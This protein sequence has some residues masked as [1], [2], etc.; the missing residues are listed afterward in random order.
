[1]AQQTSA[2]WKSLWRMKNT[3]REYGFDI[4]GTWYGPEDEVT[5]TAD[6]GLYEEFSIGNASTASLTVSLFADDIPRAAVVKRY[7]RL[8]NGGQVSEWLPKGVYFTNRRAEDD[9]YW[10]IEAYDAMRK[11]EVVWA[12]DQNNLS[13]PLS[14]PAAVS[15][16][17]RIMGVD[18]DPRTQLNPAYTI[19]YPANDY[20]IR[21]EL[22]YIAAAHAGNWIITDE[23]KLLLV[24]LLSIPPETFY[25]V[26][27][28]GDPI[29]FGGDRILV[30]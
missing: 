27:E 15:E 18:I 16:F 13:F 30:G 22:R 25:L 29:T 26:D 11:A 7:I 4:A 24:S 6:N 21:D 28:Y 14:M 1:M 10:T 9:G 8:R 20:T 12:P 23:G 2:L 3:I 19:D 17:A 5:H